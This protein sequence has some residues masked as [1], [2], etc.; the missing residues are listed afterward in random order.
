MLKVRFSGDWLLYF[1]L[2]AATGLFI[3]A[4]Y[5]YWA[6]GNKLTEVRRKVKNS[7]NKL[8][9][10]MAIG[11]TQE[12]IEELNRMLLVEGATGYQKKHAQNFFLEKC[13]SVVSEA[14]IQQRIEDAEDLSRWLI[15]NKDDLTIRDNKFCFAQQAAGSPSE[16]K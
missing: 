13:D 11:N 12:A 3:Y 14:I 5:P 10:L 4:Y 9:A 6:Y 7:E 2:A 1:A 16:G 15:H 8:L